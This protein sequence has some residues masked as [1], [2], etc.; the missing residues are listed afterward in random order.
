MLHDASVS[1]DMF[2]HVWARFL[3]KRPGRKFEKTYGTLTNIQG[4]KLWFFLVV[5]A[6]GP[7]G[8]LYEQ[9]CWGIFADLLAFWLDL[10]M[11][12]SFSIISHWLFFDLLGVVIARYRKY[13]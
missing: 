2:G 11:F 5:L 9:C 8:G 10:V 6:S 12:S 4:T 7:R 13:P 1:L 3:E